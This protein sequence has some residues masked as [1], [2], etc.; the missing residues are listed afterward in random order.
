MNRAQMLLDHIEK[1]AI[2]YAK[3][4]EPAHR[5]AVRAEMQIRQLEQQIR[6]LLD[7]IASMRWPEC[8]AQYR[9]YVESMGVTWA[10]D[11]YYTPAH[12][13]TEFCPRADEEI[14]VV[15]VY[16]ADPKDISLCLTDE[17]MRNIER[18]ISDII[19]GRVES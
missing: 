16:A 6:S 5:D 17:T 3:G 4:A 7:E 9:L 14:E 13:A 10:V 12:P 8:T 15:R 1:A 19:N 11:Y 2:Q 18:Q